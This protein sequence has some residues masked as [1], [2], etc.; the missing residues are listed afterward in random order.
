MPKT[1]LLTVRRGNG[2]NGYSQI[3]PRSEKPARVHGRLN[4]GRI[5]FSSRTIQGSR[6]ARTGNGSTGIAPVGKALFGRLFLGV[7][8]NASSFPFLI[9]R[10]DQHKSCRVSGKS[11]RAP[12]RISKGDIWNFK[13][14][15]CLPSPSLAVIFSSVFLPRLKRLRGRAFPS[16]SN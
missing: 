15:F 8:C 12:T 2:P 10:I 5:V 13:V 14:R 6:S 3:Q 16:T 9:S 1:S 11:S 7:D 4:L